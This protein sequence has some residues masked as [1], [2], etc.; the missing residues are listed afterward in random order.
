MAKVLKEERCEIG[1]TSLLFVPIEH[2]PIRLAF[3]RQQLILGFLR[4][5]YTLTL[6]CV[7]RIDLILSD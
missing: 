5:A 1:M 3:H 2:Q 6:F 7:R 4:K